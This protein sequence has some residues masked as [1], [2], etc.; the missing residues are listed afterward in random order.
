MWLPVSLGI[1]CAWPGQQHKGCGCC[2]GLVQLRLEP[3]KI[4]G[5][6]SSQGSRKS[7]SIEKDASENVMHALCM[8]DLYALAAQQAGLLQDAAV[9]Q[10]L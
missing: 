3:Q 7:I 4:I 6:A 10:L 5:E 1:F 9:H 2:R 8:V